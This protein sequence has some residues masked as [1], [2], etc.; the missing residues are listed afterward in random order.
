[1]EADGR[2]QRLLEEIRDVQSEHLAEYRRVTEQSLD[3]QRRAVARQEQVSQLYTRIA[4]LAGALIV[5]LLSLLL[6]I[7]VRWSSD[8]FR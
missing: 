2:T 8:L 7:L 3:L 4:I 6:Y 5:G 1:M